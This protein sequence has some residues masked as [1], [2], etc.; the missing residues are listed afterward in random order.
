MRN[1]LYAALV[2]GCLLSA[3]ASQVA[4]PPAPTIAGEMGATATGGVRREAVTMQATVVGIDRRERIV[5]LL[6]HDG[7]RDKVL[8]GDEVRNFDQIKKGDVVVVTYYQAIAF[9]VLDPD[10]DRDEATETVGVAA[11]A[12]GD[13]PGGL[14]A[15]S[16]TLVVHV[17]EIDEQN[18]TA[19]LRGPDGDTTEVDVLNPAAFEKVKVGDKVE[20]RLT[21]AM[22]IDVQR[23]GP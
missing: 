19:V 4:P 22:A 18:G 1:S 3:C 8:V 9:D 14:A 13:L 2:S 10:D 12:L 20:I 23:T 16:R 5:T 7:S 21:D 6:G 11:A 17:V 15:R